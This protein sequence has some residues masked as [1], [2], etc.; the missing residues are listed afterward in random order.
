MAKITFVVPEVTFK[1]A[2]INSQVVKII[3]VV[4]EI[5]FKVALVTS[6]VLKISLFKWPRLLLWLCGITYCC[7]H[8]FSAQDNICGG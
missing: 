7:D 4:A 2:M 6:S 8:F 5:F 3:F 1:V